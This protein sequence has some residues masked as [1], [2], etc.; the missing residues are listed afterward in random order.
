MDAAYGSNEPN[1][2]RGDA[3]RVGALTRL[4]GFVC[5]LGDELRRDLD[6]GSPGSD[7]WRDRCQ[8]VESRQ[9]QL[10]QLQQMLDDVR[11]TTP[12]E[13]RQILASSAS[14]SIRSNGINGKHEAIAVPDAL[15]G[16]VQELHDAIGRNV[17]LAR[18]EAVLEAYC[19]EQNKVLSAVESSESRLKHCEAQETRK[20]EELVQTKLAAE[21]EALELKV[22]WRKDR[23]QLHKV[24]CELQQANQTVAS[25]EEQLSEAFQKQE[26]QSSLLQSARVTDIQATV[27]QS[28]LSTQAK[29]MER[30]KS[31]C[32]ELDSER[33]LTH[34]QYQSLEAWAADAK[35]VESQQSLQKKIFQERCVE[36]QA[37][38]DKSRVACYEKGRE[39]EVLKIHFEEQQQQLQEQISEASRSH[40][41]FDNLKKEKRTLEDKVTDLE[42]QI[43]ESLLSGSYHASRHGQ[44]RARVEDL[45]KGVDQ[46]SQV[47]KELESKASKFQELE[48]HYSVANAAR[49]ALARQC[50]LLEE[51][52]G[53]LEGSLAKEL[54][55]KD[56]ALNANAALRLQLESLVESQRFEVHRIESEASKASDFALER[57]EAQ[58]QEQA[59]SSAEELKQAAHDRA[60][61]HSEFAS[62]EAALEIWNFA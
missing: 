21:R 24:Q 57:F 2:S 44:L 39:L 8:T 14:S 13:M 3:L 61:L 62:A 48:N 53:R 60:R 40:D 46:K 6:S 29:E 9:A 25:L 17:R 20:N 18:R 19:E 47:L 4:R 31:R 58:Q 32:A 22:S 56:D 11:E 36:L 43:A 30:L 51:E 55:E 38:L 35:Q 45:S 54:R 10:Q 34:G 15:E 7:G 5:A 28:K 23:M 49:D 1:P 41:R 37:K 16:V 42:V 26:A 12:D 50:K 33:Q 27:W 59:N 52:N